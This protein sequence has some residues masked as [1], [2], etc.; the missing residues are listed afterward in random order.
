MAPILSPDAQERII[1]HARVF[2]RADLLPY[3]AET[4][5]TGSS[6]RLTGVFLSSKLTAIATKSCQSAH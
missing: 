6:G 3:L 5:P 1:Q 2:V 4:Y